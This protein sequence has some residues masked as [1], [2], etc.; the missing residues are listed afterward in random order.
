MTKREITPHKGGRSERVNIRATP[1]TK[2][3]LELIR[4][5]TGKSAAD[6]LEEA[7]QAIANHP[8]KN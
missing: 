4:Q 3:L 8:P 2:R 7:V 5:R 6:I 1:E